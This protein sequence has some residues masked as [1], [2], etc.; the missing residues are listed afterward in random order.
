MY[1]ELFWVTSVKLAILREN[2]LEVW[3][4]IEYPKLVDN[5]L[6]EI[7]E[8][9]NSSEFVFHFLNLCVDD[10]YADGISSCPC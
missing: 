6:N 3:K 5:F 10:V 7:Y 4:S 8:Q 9:K 2:S 1:T